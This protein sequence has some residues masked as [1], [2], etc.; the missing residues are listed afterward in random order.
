ML[1]ES[2]HC[3]AA[4]KPL[5]ESPGTAR[6]HRALGNSLAYHQTVI[7]N[8]MSYQFPET[9]RQLDSY[10]TTGP[11]LRYL[12]IVGAGVAGLVLGWNPAV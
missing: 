1:N 7:F 5:A 3:Q 8:P 12:G 2:E 4:S 6:T 10:S 9:N 11:P